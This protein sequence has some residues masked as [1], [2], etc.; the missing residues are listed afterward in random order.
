MY[1]YISMDLYM[2]IRTMRV[3]ASLVSIILKTDILSHI[4]RCLILRVF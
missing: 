2:Y 1:V 3:V 4:M